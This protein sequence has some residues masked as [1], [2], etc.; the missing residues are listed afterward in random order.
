MTPSAFVPGSKVKPLCNTIFICTEGAALA[1][2]ES[3][4]YN[5]NSSNPNTEEGRP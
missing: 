4:L 1:S 5:S 3:W 2:K